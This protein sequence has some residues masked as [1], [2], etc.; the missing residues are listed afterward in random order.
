MEEALDAGVRCY[1]VVDLDRIFID[2]KS[3]E[4]NEYRDTKKQYSNNS[5]IVFGES[6]PSFEFWLLLHYDNYKVKQYN[7]MGD[8]ER[9]LKKKIKNYQKSNI[10]NYNKFYDIETIGYACE[11]AKKIKIE[12]GEHMSHSNVWKVIEGIGIA[13]LKSCIGERSN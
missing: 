9:D 7:N 12:N 5:N 13:N 8:D 3:S 10:D 11:Q 1:Y 4:E 6:M 2:G